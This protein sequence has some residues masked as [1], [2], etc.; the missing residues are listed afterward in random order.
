MVLVGSISCN[1]TRNLVIIYRVQLH[2]FVL[3]TIL[4]HSLHLCSVSLQLEQQKGIQQI[5][6][7][8]IK[9]ITAMIQVVFEMLFATRVVTT[10]LQTG[11]LTSHAFRPR[12]VLR[13]YVSVVSVGEAATAEGTTVTLSGW[14][15]TGGTFRVP[16]KKITLRLVWSGGLLL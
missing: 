8:T 4:V 16:I 1:N 6:H 11:H 10:L 5:G 9:S 14:T 12:S 7:R 2:G 15:I 13:L 3:P